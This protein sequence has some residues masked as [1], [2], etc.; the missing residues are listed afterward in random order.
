M[1]ASTALMPKDVARTPK[2]V[3]FR[4]A[5]EMYGMGFRQFERLVQSGAL[6]GGVKIGGRRLFAVSVVQKHL[7]ELEAKHLAELE[8]AAAR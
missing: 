8:A 5:A 4:E 6:P 3:G 2:F 7:A 1:S